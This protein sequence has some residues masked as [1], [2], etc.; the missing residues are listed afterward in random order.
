V[1]IPLD[2]DPDRIADILRE[3]AETEILP[4]FRAL[5]SHEISEKKP[6]DLVTVADKASEAML[7]ARLRDLIPGA[8]IVGEEGHET[9]P[10]A[11]SELNDADWAWILDPL[12]GTHNFAHG[13]PRFAVIAAL[14]HRGETVMG[15]IY[16]PVNR[17]LAATEKGAGAWFAGDKLALPLAPPVA[18]M[19]GSLGY[20]AAD[21]LRARRDVPGMPPVPKAFKRYRCVGLEYQDLARAKLDFARYAG[22]LMPWDHAA[23]VLLYREAGG[24]AAMTAD[25]RSY[26]PGGTR[27]GDALLLAP[28]PD[29]W[30]ALNGL[31]S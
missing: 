5:E 18:E 14:A 11:L 21:R 2:I 9:N 30:R 1:S 13:T 26:A 22:R 16:D 31:M 3:T 23:G 28:D 25:A 15:W 27:P 19:T 24:Q 17:H 29:A 8:L 4:R 12:D 10:E 20:K 7:T 6:G